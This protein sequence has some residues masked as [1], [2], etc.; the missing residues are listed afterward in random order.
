MASRYSKTAIRSLQNNL[1]YYYLQNRNLNKINHYETPRLK[2]LRSF[3]NLKVINHT[4][5]DGDRFMKL[6]DRYYSEP[7]LWCVI[8]YYNLTPTELY[9]IPGMN[10]QIPYPIEDIIRSVV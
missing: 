9:V 4:W 7:T 2:N 5:I 1:Y 10:I 8:A 3:Q 6:A